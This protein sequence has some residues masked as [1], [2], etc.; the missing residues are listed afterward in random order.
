MPQLSA[1]NEFISLFA[2]GQRRLYACIRSQVSNSHDADDVFQDVSKALWEHFDEFQPGTDFVRWAC[3]F[4]RFH[5]LAHHRHRKRL[6]AILGD[7]LLDEVADE[8]CLLDETIDSRVE[9]LTGCMQQLPPAVRRMLEQ[10]FVQEMTVAEIA[11]QRGRTVSAVY[12]TLQKV[13]DAL[14][15][16]IEAALIRRAVR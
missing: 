10:R 13:R 6:A 8:V 5:V 3:A 15:D 16:C 7:D 2:Q 14:F 11:A 9:A 1:T 12:K 4:A